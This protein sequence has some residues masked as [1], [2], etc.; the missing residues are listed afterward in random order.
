MGKGFRALLFAAILIGA[1]VIGN[2]I[3]YHNNSGKLTDG[4][5]NV[6]KAAGPSAEFK[7]FPNRPG[8]TRA[9][10]ALGRAATLRFEFATKGL[11]VSM[12]KFGIPK[13]FADM[14]VIIDPKE[15]SVKE[16]KA[17]ST[18]IFAV[19]PG[20]PLGK[21][22]LVIVAVDAKTNKEIGRGE[23]PFMLLPAGVGGC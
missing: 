8:I 20:T 18:V 15:V 14:G 9:Q 13:K 7:W 3:S 10:I 16:N 4:I 23:L 19:P 5:L 17:T 1:I 22:E 21:F 6:A 12:V 11:N 2:G